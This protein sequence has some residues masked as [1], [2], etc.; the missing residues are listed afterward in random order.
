MHVRQA[1][2]KTFLAVAIVSAS[3][4]FLTLNVCSGQ[5]VSGTVSVGRNGEHELY[6][7]MQGTGEPVVLIHTWGV[8]R[9]D[10]RLLHD[11]V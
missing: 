8:S 10:H 1:E 9:S 3:C 2:V 6:Y 4:Q 7:E 5:I 11:V